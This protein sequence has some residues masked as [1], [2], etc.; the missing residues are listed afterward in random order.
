MF[1]RVPWRSPWL[2]GLTGL[3]FAIIV[4]AVGP[5][6][7]EAK[8]V[9]SSLLRAQD[10]AV[11]LK[12][13]LASGDAEGAAV[14][15]D[16][17]QDDTSEAHRLSSG[18]MWDTAAK[19]PWL[20]RNVEAVQITA[21]SID[22]IAARGL[23]PL[24]EAGSSL[25]VKSF[26]PKDGQIDVETLASLAPAVAS[27][28]DV[29]DANAARI[30][31]ID[32]EGLVGP[33]VR[34]VLDLQRQVDQ[35]DRAADAAS[36]VMRLAPAS[37]GAGDDQ[38][39]LLV[40]QTNAEIRSTGGMGGVY[41]LLSSENGRITLGEQSSA[42]ELNVAPDGT[43]YPDAEL[44]KDEEAAFG[45]LMGR[46]VRSTN[47]N[48]DFPRVA[49]IWADR[50]EQAYGVDIDGV[51][52]LDAVAMSYVLQGVGTV[53]LE[54][55]EKLTPDAALDRLLN[56]VYLEYEDP[57]DQNE[58]FEDATGRTFE[59]VMSGR[60]DWTRIVSALS[61]AASERRLQM[62]FRDKDRQKVI[63]DTAVAARV[64]QAGDEPHVG[65]YITDS[66]QSKMQYY[67]RYDTRV[68]A[69]T[70]TEDRGQA[71]LVTT[72]FRNQFSGNPQKAPWYITG[73][74]D[75]TKKGN[76][77]LTYRLLAPKGGKVTGFTIDGAEQS[78]ASSDVTYKGRP[79][80]YG[81]LVV[82]PG[83]EISV[84]WR[85]ETA[86][87]ADGD[88]RYFETPGITTSSNDIRVP[89]ACG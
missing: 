51:I 75:R 44:T 5:F 7:L 56:G 27:A 11:V 83:D 21:E 24:V 32:P 49:Q 4:F 82:E 54:G 41:V 66:A 73:L 25:S 57:A 35:A 10:Q 2:W 34:P 8:T 62:W 69:T 84:T 38:N 12:D 29:L 89:S 58:Y 71:I 30:R 39:Y 42:S 33:L 72:S 45:T 36:R 22:D 23:P 88:A 17:L 6:A 46:D 19:V 1:S 80:Q 37:L 14:S 13:Q 61:D 16:R 52:S 18:G 20:G 85:V 47:I 48:P 74:G 26:K 59:A 63:A 40:F 65:L 9:A 68:K 43:R 64:A 70:C 86:P 76:Q 81:T 87:G 79:V 28:S 78:L 31:G 3:G 55:G 15:L 50:A 53:E 77:L 67:L 60:G